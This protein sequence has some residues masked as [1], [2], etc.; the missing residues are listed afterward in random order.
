MRK[1]RSIKTNSAEQTRRLAQRIGACIPAGTV[2]AAQGDLGA[3]KTVFAAGLAAGLGIGAVI[4]SPTFIYFTEYDEGRL[5]FVHIDAY[6]LENMDYEEKA[7][8]G[9]DECFRLDQVVLVEWP[10][11]V[12][13]WLPPETV[14]LS[15]SRCGDEQRQLCFDYDE[16]EVWLDEALGD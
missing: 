2:I 3:G 9:L 14:R 11:F 5:P 16:Q 6:R 15:I 7:L 10:Q 12:S 13:E 8:V 4:S 1:T